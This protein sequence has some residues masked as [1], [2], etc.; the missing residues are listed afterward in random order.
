MDAPSRAGRACASEPTPCLHAR[1]PRAVEPR[2]AI[3]SCSGL[4]LQTN[5]GTSAS[6]STSVCAHLSRATME[7]SASRSIL[8][9]GISEPLGGSARNQI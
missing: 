4:V 1:D 3:R 9:T 8:R 6:K 5:T 2:P 7:P